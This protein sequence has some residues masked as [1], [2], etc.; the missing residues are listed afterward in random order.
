MALY[1]LN[2]TRRQ[3]APFGLSGPNLPL[4][5]LNH[6]QAHLC[7]TCPSSPCTCTGV[8]TLAYIVAGSRRTILF[9]HLSLCPDPRVRPHHCGFALFLA[10]LALFCIDT[11]RMHFKEGLAT[12]RSGP[13]TSTQHSLEGCVCAHTRVRACVYTCACA[14]HIAKHWAHDQQQ[15]SIQTATCT[16][17]SN[18]H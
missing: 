5:P 3:S 7:V 6:P 2:R 9:C 14:T 11:S 13:A 17:T 4:P 16:C 10:A 18:I 8:P 1:L 12:R 15:P